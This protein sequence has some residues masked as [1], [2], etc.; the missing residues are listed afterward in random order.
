MKSLLS[1]AITAVLAAQA[2]FGES[3]SAREA[4]R[5]LDQAA[6]GPTPSS[7]AAVRLLGTANWLNAQFALNTS[8]LPDQSHS[9]RGRPAE[10]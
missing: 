8:D 7:I 4:A 6:W 3:I 5:F 9:H 1:L 10:Q 2:S